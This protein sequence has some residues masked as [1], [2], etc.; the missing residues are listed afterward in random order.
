[1]AAPQNFDPGSNYSL[2]Q[3]ELQKSSDDLMESLEDA[4][5]SQMANFSVNVSKLDESL[6]ARETGRHTN[7]RDMDSAQ[8]VFKQPERLSSRI[9]N[10]RN[11]SKKNSKS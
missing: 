9:E 8:N 6:D 11:A 10:R 5:A 4:D 2:S 1:M 3:A 7:R